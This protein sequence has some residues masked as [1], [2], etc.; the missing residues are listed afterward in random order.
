MQQ[1]GIGIIGTGSIAD[2]H[3]KAIMRS[4][5]AKLVAVLS[6]HIDQ[7]RYFVAQKLAND[8]TVYLDIDSFTKDPSVDIIIVCS[9]DKLHFDHALKC[10]KAGKH[11]LVEKP[12]TTN[13]NDC[14]YL[15]QQAN[16]YQ[17]ILATG[18]HLR[19][20]AGHRSLHERVVEGRALGTIRHVRA[21]WAWPQ[22]DD[23]S[24]RAKDNLARWWSLS[25]V[26][27]HC[28]DIARW[29][30]NDFGEF[31]SLKSITSNAIWNGP[32]DETAIVIG[33][34]P[35][36]VTI[37][38]VSSVQFGPY[39]RLEIFGSEGQAICSETFGRLGTGEI[40]IN[41]KTLDFT[42]VNPFY[43]Q[44]QNLVQCVQN[45]S[46]PIV[47]SYAGLRNVKDLELSM[48]VDK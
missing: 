7:G 30:A 9:P 2:E 32:H 17:V 34:L 4:D 10:I 16:K 26:G 40:L 21:I 27:T 25:A 44:I 11:V 31:S 39:N 45:Q 5:N 13:V 12:I 29:F 20:H 47:D 6:R 19:H 8:A 33:V 22:K 37:E 14:N 41:G 24:W 28:F 43:A 36:N 46:M 35:S 3:A 42:P 38:I 18:F 23:S 48:N 15:I 1:I